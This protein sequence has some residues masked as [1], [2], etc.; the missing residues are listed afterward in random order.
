[1]ANSQNEL[2][3]SYL[4]CPNFNKF[5]KSNIDEKLRYYT[6]SVYTNGFIQ[7]NLNTIREIKEVD[8]IYKILNVSSASSFELVGTHQSTLSDHLTYQRYQQYYRGVFVEGGGYSLGTPNTPD[9]PCLSASLM[10]SYIAYDID[11]DVVPSLNEDKVKEVLSEM[12]GVEKEKIASRLVIAHNIFDDCKYHLVWKCFSRGEKIPKVYFV[13]AH[14]G[15]ILK[16]MDEGLNLKAPTETYGF[17]NLNDFTQNGKTRLQNPDGSVIAYDFGKFSE[18]MKRSIS[19]FQPNLVPETTDSVWKTTIAPA[20]VYQ[21]FYTATE[22]AKAY[23]TMGI[24]FK[25]VNIGVNCGDDNSN[26]ISESTLDNAFIVIGKNSKNSYATFDIVAHELAHVYLF[27]FLN[28]SPAPSTSFLT[29]ALNEGLSDIFGTYIES[30]IQGKVDWVMGDDIGLKERN[31]ETYNCL[32]TL[33][34]HS[35]EYPHEISKPLGHWFFLV[36]QGSTQKDIPALGMEKTLKILMD[37]LAIVGPNAEYNELYEKTL[38]VANAKYG[39]CSD[40]VKAIKRAW[41][42][43]CVIK[44]VQPCGFEIKT[45]FKIENGNVLICEEQNYASFCIDNFIPALKYR[46]Y[47]PSGWVIK[48]GNPNS[49]MIE[50]VKCVEIIDFPK[51]QY[52][53]QY[54]SVDVLLLTHSTFVKKQIK[55]IDCS[56]DDPPCDNFALITPNKPPSESDKEEAFVRVFDINGKLVFNGTY[57]E[58][59]RLSDYEFMNGLIICVHYDAEGRQIKTEKRLINNF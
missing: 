2:G 32:T 43:I 23:K 25:K 5:A 29:H 11:I 28:H 44:D 58:Y 21:A 9:D 59:T 49:N 40:E 38:I 52:Y 57:A 7:F 54:L 30:I 4:G 20:S 12:G 24:N 6:D 10:A 51:Y 1:M 50:N 14:T 31:L 45:D 27:Q 18:C 22:V 48:G 42:A 3:K 35:S 37:A 46:W 41:A 16:S 39:T 55:L 56:G 26:A 53:P 8:G 19:D 13:D 36:S 17:K 47:F 34:A 33:L 15:I